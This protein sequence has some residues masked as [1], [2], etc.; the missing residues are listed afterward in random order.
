MPSS[1]EHVSNRIQGER[2][3]HTRAKVINA[4]STPSWSLVLNLA[5]TR[6]RMV[7][8]ERPYRI[9]HDTSIRKAGNCQITDGFST[10]SGEGHTYAMIW[11]VWLWDVHGG[12]ESRS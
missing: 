2:W 5:K 9:Q 10:G 11:S 4:S 12:V 1:W 7:I 8:V 3:K 6:S